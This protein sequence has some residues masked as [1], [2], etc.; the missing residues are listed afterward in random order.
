MLNLSNFSIRRF[1]LE[2]DTNL[3]TH[4]RVAYDEL[5]SV[6]PSI[7]FDVEPQI[8]YPGKLSTKNMKQSEINTNYTHLQYVNM[9]YHHHHHHHFRLLIKLTCAT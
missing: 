4:E 8:K 6:I 3:L 1:V 5:C 2:S 9:L 7:S